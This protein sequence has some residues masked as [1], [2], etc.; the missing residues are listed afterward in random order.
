MIFSTQAGMGR[1]ALASEPRTPDATVSEFYVWYLHDLEADHDPMHDERAELSG[2]VSKKLIAEIEQ[3]LN[4]A[5]G[6][7]ADY[8]T[9]AQDYMDDWATHVMVAKSTINA[10][11]AVL[12]V[13]LGATKDSLRRLRVTLVQEDKTWKIRTVQLLRTA[14]SK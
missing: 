4:S 5:D 6:M 1:T 10:G 3:K 14:D 2:Y 7:D 13:S 11:N 8:F 9:K 12:I